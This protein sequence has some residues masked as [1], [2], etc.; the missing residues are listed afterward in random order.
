MYMS[1]RSMEEV[2]ETAAAPLSEYRLTTLFPWV[3]VK[4]PSVKMDASPDS[5]IPLEGSKAEVAGS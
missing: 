1:V 5:L 3:M 2:M 4:V